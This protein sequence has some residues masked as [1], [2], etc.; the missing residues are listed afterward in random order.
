MESFRREVRNL[1]HW[2]AL[3]ALA[4]YVGVIA[5]GC[6]VRYPAGNLFLLFSPW[7]LVPFGSAYLAAGRS[8][9][10]TPLCVGLAIASAGTLLI[11]QIIEW[12]YDFHRFIAGGGMNCG[13][14][15]LHMAAIFLVLFMPPLQLC[16]INF[17]AS[18]ADWGGAEV[19]DVPEDI[20]MRP[21]G[22][23]STQIQPAKASDICA[24]HWPRW[25]DAP[26]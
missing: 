7:G 1:G 24:G 9:N 20:A 26:G 17:F 23:A 11:W 8:K 15:L 13:P 2:V 3:A 6:L 12:M 19:F 21:A 25:P 14:P 10:S 5:W 4:A 18:L 22:A 16:L